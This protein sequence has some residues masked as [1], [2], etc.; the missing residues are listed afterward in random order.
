LVDECG[1]NV[2]SGD[3]SYSES[4]GGCSL[5]DVEGSVLAG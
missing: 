2:L 4:V 5:P 3:A 1:E